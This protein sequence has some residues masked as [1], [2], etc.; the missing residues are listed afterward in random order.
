MPR[1]GDSSSTVPE[2]EKAASQHPVC[3]SRGHA[4]Y[5]AVQFHI[6]IFILLPNNAIDSWN[7]PAVLLTLTR[8]VRFVVEAISWTH[9]LESN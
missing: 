7:A 5:S 4:R 8:R 2:P 9:L 6:S 1:K 3:Y